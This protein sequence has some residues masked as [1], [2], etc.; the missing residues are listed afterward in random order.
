M[1]EIGDE[2]K[3]INKYLERKFHEKSKKKCERMVKQRQRIG[4]CNEL[5]KKVFESFPDVKKRENELYQKAVK[6]LAQKWDEQEQKKWKQIERHKRDRIESHT[7]DK[8]Q[9]I[10]A[11]NYQIQFH[12]IEKE[13]RKINEKLDFIFDRQQ[14]LKKIEQIKSLREFIY[15]QIEQDKRARDKEIIQNRIDT[16]RAIESVIQNEDQTFFSY[17]SKL[18]KNAKKNG[19]PLKPLIKTIEEYKKHNCLL[20]HRDHLP[21]LKSDIDIGISLR[22]K[23]SNKLISSEK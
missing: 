11:Q 16:N 6:E 21:H 17:A 1:S 10:K 3:R 8:D 23:Y 13:E 7:K 15:E 2:Q 12:K 20:A 19:Y 14:R 9:M 22:R 18:L 5:A 4:Q